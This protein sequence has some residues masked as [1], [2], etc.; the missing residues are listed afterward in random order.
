MALSLLILLKMTIFT[1][2]HQSK[3]LLDISISRTPRIIALS[4]LMITANG[5]PT[6]IPVPQSHQ[7]VVL[8]G[9]LLKLM[10]IQFRYHHLMPTLEFS[11]SRNQTLHWI[12]ML[13][14]KLIPGIDQWVTKFS[15]WES[16]MLTQE[17]PDLLVIKPQGR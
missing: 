16:M 11:I 15:L 17:D 7:V 10:L 13:N 1:H 8:N 9:Y 5:I 2:S 4:N 14:T 12:W 3:A 6:I